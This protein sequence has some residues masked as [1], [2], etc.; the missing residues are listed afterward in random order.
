MAKCQNCNAEI[1][2]N[3]QKSFVDRWLHPNDGYHITIESK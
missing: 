3:A 1:D 2:E